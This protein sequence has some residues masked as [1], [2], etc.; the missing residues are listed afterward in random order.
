V[1][2]K[3]LPCCDVNKHLF[4]CIFFGSERDGTVLGGPDEHILDDPRDLVAL[5]SLDNDRLSGFLR[6]D[7]GWFFRVSRSLVPLPLKA[8]RHSLSL[9]FIGYSHINSPLYY[10]ILVPALNF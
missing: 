10:K 6:D 3:S 2:V 8:L 7:F 5:A 9:D 4:K 1:S